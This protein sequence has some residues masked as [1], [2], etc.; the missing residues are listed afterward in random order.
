M[1]EGCWLKK[2]HALSSKCWCTKSVYVS[3]AVRTLGS[4]TGGRCLR[5]FAIRLWLNSVDQIWKLDSILD[6][7]D[8]DIVWVS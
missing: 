7:E 5:N 1:L 6:K 8:W 2:S 3:H 4:R